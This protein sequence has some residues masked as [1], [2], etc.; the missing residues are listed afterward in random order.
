MFYMLCNIII[1]SITK[2]YIL[3]GCGVHVSWCLKEELAWT[4]VQK[5]RMPLTKA[6]KNK[7]VLTASHGLLCGP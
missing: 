2:F 7:A 6:L 5:S 3:Q 1:E 4:I